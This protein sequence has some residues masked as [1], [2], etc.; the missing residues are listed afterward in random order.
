MAVDSADERPGPELARILSTVLS[1][2]ATLQLISVLQQPVSHAGFDVTVL[3]LLGTVLTLS[4]SEIGSAWLP[5]VRVSG[6]ARI[7]VNQAAQDGFR[8]IRS[9]SRSVTVMWLP[10]CSP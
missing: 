2:L 10:S 6:G 3:G 5:A 9:R 8:W 1:G 7:F 4:R